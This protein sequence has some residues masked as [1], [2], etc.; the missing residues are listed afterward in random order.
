[1]AQSS[2]LK[3]DIKSEDEA[4]EMEKPEIPRKKEKPMTEEKQKL[5]HTEK[6]RAQYA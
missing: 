4:T 3:T 5:L 6:V 2:H 1:M